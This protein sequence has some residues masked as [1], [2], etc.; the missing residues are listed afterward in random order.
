MSYVPGLAKPSILGC[1][2]FNSMDADSL[3]PRT[4]ELVKRRESCMG[5]SYRLFYKR[6]LNLV[7]GEGQYLCDAYG[8]KYLYAYNYFSSM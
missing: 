6:P 3:D 8:Y 7:K 4:R 5:S 2:R 1:N